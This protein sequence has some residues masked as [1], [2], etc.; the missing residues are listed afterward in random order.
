MKDIHSDC[1]IRHFRKNSHVKDFFVIFECL[2]I[3]GSKRFLQ[4]HLRPR[5]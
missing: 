4:V 5:L 1:G 2:F 3:S